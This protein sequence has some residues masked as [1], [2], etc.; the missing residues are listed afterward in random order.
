[1]D[2]EDEIHVRSENEIYYDDVIAPALLEM[3]KDMMARGMSFVAL[4]EYDKG[5]CASTLTPVDAAT[6]SAEVLLTAMA[7]RSRGNV[8]SLVI[9]L[10]KHCRESNRSHSSIFLDRAGVDPDPAKR[11]D[12]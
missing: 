7:A 10:A 11:S 9:G 5:H 2:D 8:D 4:V 3:T 1:M 6:A 12:A